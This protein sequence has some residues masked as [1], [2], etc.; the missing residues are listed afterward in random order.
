MTP[1]QKRQY[2]E[3]PSECPVCGAE[4]NIVSTVDGND[5]TELWRLISCTNPE[6]NL[7]FHEHFKLVGIEEIQKITLDNWIDS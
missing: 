5:L 4:I 6:C 3:N 7:K 2:I 1:E